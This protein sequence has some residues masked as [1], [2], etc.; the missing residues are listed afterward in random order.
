MIDIHCHVLPGVDDGAN[1]LDESIAI[2]EAAARDGT[3]TVVATP[4]GAEGAYGG[5]QLETQR[6]VERLQSELTRRGVEL[7]VL[8]GLEVRIVPDLAFLHSEG[9]VFTL[10]GSRYLLV[11]LP[12]QTLPLYTDQALFDLQL[13]QLVPVIAHPERN[14]S[15]AAS[16]EILWRMV[17]RGML[18]Q[19]T[20]GSLIGLFG[21]RTREVAESLVAH[22]M[23]QI[24]ASDAHS[25]GSRGRGPALSAAVKRAEE[26]IGREAAEAMVTITPL[27]IIRNESIRVPEPE[28]LGQRRS[29]FR[30][31]RRK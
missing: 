15:I 28:P 6:R 22:R 4:H 30:F 23:V 24:I 17:D 25:S 26:L 18:A 13:R 20:A 16:P 19:V 31:G 11:E 29:W 1:D 21:P 3:R 27:A 7:E 2:A 9:R 10:N 8:A 12:P 14:L 5:D